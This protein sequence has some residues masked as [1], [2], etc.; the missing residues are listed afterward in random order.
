M[1]SRRSPHREPPASCS[2][3]GARIGRALAAALPGAPLEVRDYGALGGESFDLVVNATSA[4]LSAGA[5]SGLPWPP[6]GVLAPGVLAY[7]MVYGRDTLFLA[8]ARAAGARARDGSGMLVEQA[9][10]SFFIW[11]GVRPDTRK[12]LAALGAG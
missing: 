4:G 10:E 12:V 8:Q 5:S 2:R 7:D 9:A 6:A 3:T 11:R 1:C